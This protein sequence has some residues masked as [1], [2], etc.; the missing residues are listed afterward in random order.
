MWSKKCSCL[1]TLLALTLGV[2]HV[3]FL[4]SAKAAMTSTNYRIRWDTI[5]NGGADN[6]SSTSYILRDTIGNPAIGSSTSSTYS[7]QGGYRFAQV[8][9]ILTFSLLPAVRTTAQD[10]AAL[11][12]TTVTIASPDS[13]DVDDYA[14]IVQD[15]GASQVAGFG[16]VVSKTATTITLDDIADNGTTPVV[17]GVNDVVYQMDGSA[18][19][20]GSVSNGDFLAMVLG[21][22]ITED[23]DNGYTVQVAE[24]GNLR[25]GSDDVND[26]SDGSVTAGSEEYGARS[27]DVTLAGSTFDTADT[28]FTTTF[29]SVSTESD[30]AFKD[31]HFLT[32][33]LAVSSG[34]ATGD[35]AQVLTLIATG[36]Y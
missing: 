31:R 34:T 14:V 18:I 35:Y 13:F 28:A 3:P 4:H 25:S 7:L 15:L 26:V 22:E 10:A 27:S 24:D 8:E 23:S 19:A 1:F 16:R 6:G 17:D 29:Q 12:G 5:S 33:K 2:L 30:L 32:L 11:T 21:W 9:E 36:N 20:F